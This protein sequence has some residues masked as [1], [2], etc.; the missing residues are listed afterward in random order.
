MQ[1]VSRADISQVWGSSNWRLFLTIAFP[2]HLW[3]IMV[4][5]WNFQGIIERSASL[6]DGVGY[7]SYALLVALIESLA[8]FAALLLLGF[9]LPKSYSERTRRVLLG[10]VGLVV[11]F[12]M[13]ISQIY[14]Y[15]EFANPGFTAH[16]V[17]RFQHPYRLAILGLGLLLISITFSV[18]MPFSLV[19]SRPKVEASIQNIFD[20]ILPL[21][22]FY[23]FLDAVGIFIVI[24]R[25][26]S[27]S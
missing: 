13:A 1:P 20:R 10:L 2:I 7:L 4:S 11:V 9:L 12:W 26:W 23:L 21:S 17:T 25:N 8:L 15:L 18:G 16:F 6:M 22:S 14:S 3:S 5:F 24:V 19:P 27:A